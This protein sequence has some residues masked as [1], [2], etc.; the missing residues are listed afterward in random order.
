MRLRLHQFRALL[1]LAFLS[2]PL[3]AQ[4][5]GI[6]IR[7]R[8]AEYD[9]RNGTYRYAGNVVVDVP[10]VLRL[11]CED[12]EVTASPT[13]SRPDRLVATTNV[14]LSV[15]RPGRDGGAP[16]EI[17][18]YGGQAVYT[19]AD[20]LVTL[21]LEPRVEAPQGTTRGEVIWYH[22]AT[23]RVRATNQVTELSPLL[24]RGSGLFGKRT[25]GPAAAP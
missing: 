1:A 13:N 10:G 25:N 15:A 22:L 18:A 21:T 16:V 11:T 4:D 20:E 24:F 6:P 12:L 5:A 3:R 9:Y 2:A 17:R 19:A 23:G 8:W 14:V 7:A